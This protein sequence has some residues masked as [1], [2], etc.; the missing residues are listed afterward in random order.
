MTPRAAAALTSSA[1]GALVCG[2][3]AFIYWD[4]A[5]SWFFNDDFHWLDQSW[6]IRIAQFADLSRYDHFYRPLIETY[7]A[8]GLNL[9][10]CDPLA[11]HRASIVI[12]VLTTGLVYLLGRELGMARPFAYVAA[13]WF[14]AQSGPVEAVAWVGAVTDLLPGFWY[15]LTVLTHA[16]FLRRGGTG[17]RFATLG[18]FAACLLT[19]ESSAT[20][21]VMLVAVDVLLRPRGAVFTREAL[22]L[23]A[24][25]YAPMAAMLVVY[26]VV[27]YVV[28]SRSYLVTE[29]YYQFGW[30]A[31]PKVLDYLVAILVW[32]RDPVP[33]VVLTTALVAALAVGTPRIRFF[34]IWVLVTLLPVLF[35]TWGIASRYQYVPAAGVALIAAELLSL[36]HA[37]SPGRLPPRAR[38]V[39]I[40]VI[41]AFLTVRST[42]FALKGVDDFRMLTEPYRVLAATVPTAARDVGN[43]V[44]VDRTVAA[45][46]PSIYLEAAVRVSL[47]QPGVGAV[48]G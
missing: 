16:A 24:A 1:A 22:R 43:R 15:V 37:A 18:G 30:H 27:A 42:Y 4:A 9:F 25:W 29:G 7:F 36:W 47:C 14:V 10:G 13:L 32:E 20:L 39:I 8:W 48:V 38:T 41:A 31:L 28:N 6:T 12:H 11:F 34:T 46:I 40:A 17:L 26:L 23:R 3:A 45:P 2:L 21:I 5:G 35:F 19:H 44:I 33:D